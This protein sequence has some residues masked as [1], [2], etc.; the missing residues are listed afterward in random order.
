[1]VTIPKVEKETLVDIDNPNG[2]P[3]LTLFYF[4]SRIPMTQYLLDPLQLAWFHSSPIVL[5]TNFHR[6]SNTTDFN[7]NDIVFALVVN[8][9][10]KVIFH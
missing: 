9:M 1:M 6:F 4:F 7:T 3:S 5:D 10:D 8:S 2:L